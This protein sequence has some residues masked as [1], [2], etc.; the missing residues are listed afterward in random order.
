MLG[1]DGARQ[2]QQAFK[3]YGTNAGSIAS[4]EVFGRD[5]GLT[6]SGKTMSFVT[7]H[8]LERNRDDYLGYQD[9]DTFTLANAWLIAQGYGSPQVFSSF[10]WEQAEDSPPARANGLITNT[11][12]GEQWTCVH[13]DPAIVAMVTWR[14]R[15]GA[16]ERTNF[17]TDDQNVVAFSG[18]SRGWV[19]FNNSTADKEIR[20]QTGL[21]GGRYCD[22]AQ[23]GGKVA[24]A[25]TGLTI[26]VG[27]TGF[28]R[29]TVGAKDALAITRA[30][31]L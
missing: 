4:L 2:I 6:P 28:A 9:G 26:T 27:T 20:V 12:C 24:G 10:A 17:W 8:D 1:V 23:G 31:R 22:T 5:S 30:D 19:A 3:S 14:D 21:P 13:R 29:V 7:N 18:G 11:V 16:A 25:C 15:V